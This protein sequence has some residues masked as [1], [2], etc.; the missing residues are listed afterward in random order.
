MYPVSWG[1]I[2]M[3][4]CREF[5]QA[6][7]DGVICFTNPHEITDGPIMNPIVSDYFLRKQRLYGYSYYAI[8]YCPF[9]GKPRSSIKQG[10]SG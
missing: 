8:N 3:S 7:K 6:F 10:F 1:M 9:C 4:C 5:D 2:Q